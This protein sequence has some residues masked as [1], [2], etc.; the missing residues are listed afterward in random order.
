MKARVC[1]GIPS[2]DTF[3][4]P[5]F[6][7]FG[8]AVHLSSEEGTWSKFRVSGVNTPTARNMCVAHMLKGD[9]THLF[10]MDSDMSFPKAT[11]PRLLAHDKDIVGGFYL[12]KKKG[13]LPNAF[14]LGHNKDD[15]LIPEFIDDFREVEAIATGCLLVKREVFETIEKPWFEYRP[16]KWSEEGRLAT[17]DVVFCEKAKEKGLKIWCDGTI[18]CGHVGM[19][20]IYPARHPE[21]GE[22]SAKYEIQ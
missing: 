19:V 22:A 1:V 2:G 11:L 10:F 15:T 14:R 20:V 4:K 17:E 9:F 5:F 12:R 16:I 21:T 8:A 3:P 18:A 7:S 6:D 13:H